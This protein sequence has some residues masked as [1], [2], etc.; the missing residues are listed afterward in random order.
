MRILILLAALAAG[1]TNAFAKVV[2]WSA[3]RSKLIRQTR[4]VELR[5]N[6]RLSRDDEEL[7]ADEIDFNQDTQFVQARGR[8][9]Y[10]YGT[11]F[12]RADSIDIDLDKKTGVITNGSL[13]N[14]GFALRGARIEQI[15][16]NRILVQDF[17]YTTCIDCP[18]SWTMTGKEVDLTIN[19]YAFINDFIFKI[20]DTPM[21]WLPYM[22]FP[23][24]TKRESGLLFPRFGVNDIHGTYFVQPTFWAIN[25]WS[26]MTLG[27]GVYTK[28]G[29]RIEWEGR[30]ALT[31]RSGG[32][33]NFYRTS[34][35]QVKG[36][37]GRF[38]LRTEITQ[39][40]PFRFEAK[41]RAN[42][43]SDSGY[44]ITYSEDVPGRFE[45][46]LS[47]DLFLSRNDPNVSTVISVR[48]IRNLL[49]YGPDGSY[50]TSFDP[51]TVQETPRVVM[52]TND[53]FLLG[54]RIAAGLE[55]RLNR[56]SRAAGP[57]DV[58]DTGSGT[59]VNVIREANRFTLIP[60]LYTTLNPWPW[61]S[62][63]PSVQYRS[64]FYNFENAPGFQNLA[65][66]YLLTQADLSFQ[67]EKVIPTENP[68]ESFKHT[69][70]PSLTWSAIPV[71]QESKDHPFFDQIQEKARPGQYFDYWDIVPLGTSQNLDSYFVPLGHSLT[72]GVTSQVFKKQRNAAGDLAV[73]RRFEVKAMQTLNIL[74]AQKKVSDGLPDRRV[75]L[76][77]L[78][79]QMNYQDEK[80]TFGAEY[81]YYSFLDNYDIP[82]LLE[83]R[84]P[85][86]VSA[87][88][89]WVFERGIRQGVMQF[90]RSITINYSFA[91]LISK[92][93]S[94]STNFNFSINDYIMPKF[95]YVFD[96]MSSPSRLLDSRYSLLFQ[97]PSRCW[98]LEAG[99]FKSIDRGVGFNVSFVLN[100]TG[101]SATPLQQ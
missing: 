58:I 3:D 68:D 31:D 44:P 11:Y 91:K 26:D 55:A 99:V 92:Y 95:A 42:E 77:P 23:V 12:V 45:P 87:N 28:R 50:L 40:F 69:I 79:A 67:I 7:F 76:S 75:L 85:H 34:D 25:K 100:L 62:L 5:G 66:G 10:Q 71:V 2:H 20:K 16:E 60:G 64:F 32:T 19:G 97:N 41:L 59:S 17:D 27:L 54:S 63:V 49:H 73:S 78:F 83:Y 82:Q 101:G 93:S 46:V 72:Y 30:Y 81:I 43:V 84:S 70:R 9:R 74:E 15:G 48:R 53:Q 61:L 33:F 94:L 90:D 21:F 57:F 36:L 86:R 52:N 47:S 37:A 1:S 38:A 51:E 24:K 29:M 14:G 22:V 88:F 8:V 13:T 4:V 56:F 65:R 89:G 98:S 80:I 18:N 6:A 96:L 39:E 35:E